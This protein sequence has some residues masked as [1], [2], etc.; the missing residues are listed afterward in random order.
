MA[1]VSGAREV[2]ALVPNFKRF[3]KNIRPPQRRIDAAK[4]YPKIVR[5]HLERS[6]RIT[7]REPHTKLTGSYA[8]RVAIHLIKDVD[9]VVFVDEIYERLGAL[10]ALLDLKAALDD[11]RDELSEDDEKP[12]IELREQRRS[13]RV[14]FKKANF[15][16]DVV[17]VRAPD[18]TDATRLLVPDREWTTWQPTGCVAYRKYFS[19][20]NQDTC[21][22]NLPKL[23]KTAKH[24]T[25]QVLLRK[26][27][28]SFWLEAL[29]V[30]LIVDGKITF[31]DKSFAEIVAET[32]HAI[33]D[34]CAPYLARDADTPIIPDPMLPLE[35]PNVAFNWDRGD[36]ETFMWRIEEACAT[37]DD[38]IAATTTVDAIAAWQKLLGAE[39]FPAR[40]DADAKAVQDAAV[41]GRIAVGTT[42]LVF[43]KTSPAS[44]PVRLV[45]E[46]R[47]HGE[48]RDE[49]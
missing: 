36:F 26:Q 19:D 10:R 12:E 48:D 20:L 21:E 44:T 35:N 7:T 41:A 25:S 5:D 43:T 49:P 8:R 31:G 47:F 30:K 37:V 1:I 42:G 33:N 17:P 24:W 32:F 28:K 46:H 34:E 2:I 27:V 18:G 29:I 15:F 16:L 45:R 22:G 11:L 39:W 3:L 13:V 6:D 4:K 40:V 38:A 14:H 9:L 23:V